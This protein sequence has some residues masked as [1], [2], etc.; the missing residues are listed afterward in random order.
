MK[1]LKPTLAENVDNKKIVGIFPAKNISY[2]KV[3]FN[4]TCYKER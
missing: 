2:L 4:I 3:K 1:S